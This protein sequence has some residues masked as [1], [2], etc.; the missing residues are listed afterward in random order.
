MLV[1]STLDNLCAE[2]PHDERPC[3][4]LAIEPGNKIPRYHN[5]YGVEDV[6]SRLRMAGQQ[7]YTTQE[8]FERVPLGWKHG[9]QEEMAVACLMDLPFDMFRSGCFCQR[10]GLEREARREFILRLLST[11]LELAG[12]T[13]RKECFTFLA[14]TFSVG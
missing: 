11:L 9:A 6:I 7:C 8:Y 4:A 3:H 1:R 13:D 10:R 2:T 14:L 5:V 12:M